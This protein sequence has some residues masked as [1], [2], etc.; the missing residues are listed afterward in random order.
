MYTGVTENL[1]RRLKEHLN[2][3]GAKYTAKHKPIEI[4]WY[5]KHRDRKEALKKEKEIKG[6]KRE[7]KIKFITSSPS[8]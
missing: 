4:L 5:S 1:E 8:G 3:R 7:K 2:K 6:W